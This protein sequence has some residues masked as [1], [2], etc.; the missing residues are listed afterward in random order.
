MIELR[1]DAL[2]VSFPEVHRD[3][4]MRI[5]FQR[6]LRIPDDDRD[7]PLPAGL[8][9][10]PLRH[11]DDFAENVPASWVEH[12]GIM[13][14]MYQAE[15][16]WLNFSV[17]YPFV[18]KVATGK[19]NTVTGEP[20]KDGVNRDP[21]DYLVVPA[22]PWLDGYCVEKGIIRQFVAMPLGNGYS[23]E[24]QVTGE[25]EHGGLQIVA[26]PLKRKAYE[27]IC[28]RE[29]RFSYDSD[30]VFCMVAEGSPAMGL[31]AGGRMRQ[32]IYDDDYDFDDWD[33]RHKSRCFVHIANSLVWRAVTGGQPPTVPPTAK[34]YRAAGIPWF[35]YYAENQTAVEGSGILQ[36]VKSVVQLGKEKSDTP[37]TDNE[38]IEIDKVV[39]LRKG[40]KKS[41]VRDGVF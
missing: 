37:L 30:T 11:V 13:L 6:T 9:R 15:A 40:L 29:E 33:F 7:Y 32:E 34:E 3:A 16:M 14:P 20:W 35:D 8:G 19:I 21:Q 17:S 10:F 38:S 41:E 27:R 25:A 5:D 12:G 28:L 24:E 36:K 31:A 2:I 23:V 26:Y 18:V 1:H 4:K 39:E 22:Q